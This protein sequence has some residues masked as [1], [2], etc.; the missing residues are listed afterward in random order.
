MHGRT[1]SSGPPAPLPS[2]RQRSA[3]PVTGTASGPTSRSTGPLTAPGAKTHTSGTGGGPGPP[4]GTRGMWQTPG[5]AAGR[6]PP[7]GAPANPKP[8]VDTQE[9]PNTSSLPG[10]PRAGTHKSVKSSS[11]SSGVN[12][13][14]SPITWG[15]GQA[16]GGRGLRH[17]CSC[18]CAQLCP[19]AALPCSGKHAHRQRLFL[20]G[21]RGHPLGEGQPQVRGS[22]QPSKELSPWPVLPALPVPAEDPGPAWGQPAL[23][24][25][26]ASA[27]RVQA[28]STRSKLT[29]PQASPRGATEHMGSVTAGTQASRDPVKP[30]HPSGWRDRWACWQGAGLAE[31]TRV[32]AEA[33][34]RG[35]RALEEHGREAR[36]PRTRPG[37][38]QGEAEETER[39]QDTK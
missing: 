21:D 5:Q 2:R 16:P 19:L 38:R 10:Q 1:V 13:S 17:P 30:A 22:P 7:Q 39:A 33:G 18:P 11:V 37:S 23:S 35:L 24:R 4:R 6:G 32:V 15:G 28:G 34:D 27:R 29:A 8:E 36:W 20:D 26:H 25:D 12:T 14:S 3:A 31:A 9:S